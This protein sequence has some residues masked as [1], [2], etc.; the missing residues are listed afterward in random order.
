MKQ[1]N[2]FGNNAKNQL[3]IT[4]HPC[5]KQKHWNCNADSNWYSKISIQKTSKHSLNFDFIESSFKCL[6]RPVWIPEYR[7]RVKF[8]TRKLW[9]ILKIKLLENETQSMKK[10]NL[11]N[12][13]HRR[14][15]QTS[16]YLKNKPGRA[17]IKNSNWILCFCLST[18]KVTE[19]SIKALFFIQTP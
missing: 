14:N 18:L 1:A 4:L 2:I 16:N 15:K 12:N 19:I 8:L 11:C 6:P 17:V 3:T 9:F 13:L 10:Q 7:A 5:L